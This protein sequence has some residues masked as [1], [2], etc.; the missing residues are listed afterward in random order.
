M[1][2]FNFACATCWSATEEWMSWKDAKEH[3][4]TCMKCNKEMEMIPSKTHF[5]LKGP[6]FY[7]T[8]NPRTGGRTQ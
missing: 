5:S 2:I 7:S 6:G 1:P 4:P 3:P 8:D